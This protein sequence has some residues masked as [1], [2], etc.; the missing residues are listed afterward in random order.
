MENKAERGMAF[1]PEVMS[2]ES[3]WIWKANELAVIVCAWAVP[4]VYVCGCPD[5]P[6]A[7]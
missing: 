4:V 3:I 2:T 6:F 7:E 1:W 5:V